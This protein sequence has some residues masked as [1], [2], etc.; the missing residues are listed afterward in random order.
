VIELRLDRGEL[1]HVVVTQLDAEHVTLDLEDR[2][3]TFTRGEIERLWTGSYIVLWRPPK[4]PPP[5]LLSEGDQGEGVAWLESALDRVEG[6]PERQRE[7]TARFDPTLKERVVHFQQANGLQTDGVV[8]KQTLMQLNALIN[9]N[10][11]PVLRLV[12]S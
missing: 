2:R 8:G 7:V 3:T 4:M 5:Y 6:R 11:T 12:G 10:G 1:Y 9:Q